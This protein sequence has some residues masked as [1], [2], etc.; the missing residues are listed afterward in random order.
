MQKQDAVIL[1]NSSELVMDSNAEARRSHPTNVQ[2]WPEYTVAD[3]FAM[4]HRSP[5]IDSSVMRI[6]YDQTTGLFS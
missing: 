6:F 4:Q 5:R 3:F 2:P 1:P